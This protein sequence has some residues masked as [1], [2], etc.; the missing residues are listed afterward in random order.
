MK[1]FAVILAAVFAGQAFA[2][3]AY[4]QQDK[5][6]EGDDGAQLATDTDLYGTWITACPSLGIPQL[7]CTVIVGEKCAGLFSDAA[8]RVVK[9]EMVKDD[10]KKFEADLK[11]C[12]KP[13]DPATDAGLCYD[14]KLSG[15][16]CREYAKQFR[17]KNKYIKYFEHPL[18]CQGK[19]LNG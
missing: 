18:S 17:E 10:L 6:A 11:A 7:Y 12:A 5:R 9:Q 15:E 13:R 3:P 19:G 14:Q 2:T 1:G 16:A 8:G 4:S